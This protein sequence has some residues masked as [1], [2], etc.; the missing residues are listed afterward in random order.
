MGP[1]AIDCSRLSSQIGTGSSHS[2]D[3]RRDTMAMFVDRVS[4]TPEIAVVG[5]IEVMAEVGTPGE[6]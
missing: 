1:E 6:E 5:E 2:G 4:V 3:V